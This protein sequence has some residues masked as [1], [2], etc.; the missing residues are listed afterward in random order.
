MTRFQ[1]L[2]GGSD[3]QDG[4]DESPLLF[5]LQEIEEVEASE[6]LQSDGL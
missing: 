2:V 6:L 5:F 4:G 1:K 3:C